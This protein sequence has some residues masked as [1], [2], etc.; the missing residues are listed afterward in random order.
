MVSKRTAE[1]ASVERK[2]VAHSAFPRD[3]AT[4]RRAKPKRRKALRF[5][6]LRSLNDDVLANTKGGGARKFGVCG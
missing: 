1:T 4:R 5:S 2:S 3:L 6:A